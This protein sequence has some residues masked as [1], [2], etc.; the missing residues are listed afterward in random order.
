MPPTS[1]LLD[2][3]HA[4]GLSDVTAV[5]PVEG[6]LAA[7]AGLATRRSGPP[8]F[9]K[10]FVDVPAGD[11]FAAEAEGLEVLRERGELATPRVVLATRDVLVLSVLRARPAREDFW[12]R[13]AHALARLH[14]TTVH[15]RFGWERD[16]WLGRCRQE[17]AWTA[18]GHEFFARRRLL[19]WLPQR[20]VRAALDER[21]RRA[22][23]R[24]CERLPEVLPPRPPCLTHGDLWA[25]NIL[26]TEEGLPALI[27]PA[28]SYT[29]AEVDLAHLWCSPHP[30]EAKRFF[31]AYAE[32]TG[33]DDDWRSR[34]PL[35][36]LRQHLAVIA[37]FDHDWGAAQQVRD[38]LKPFRR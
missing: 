22:L 38:T 26:A 16:N 28:V 8:L 30:P 4:A 10:S 9:V 2:R 14:T 31:G 37:Q 35:I 11:L 18:D 7:L 29:W 27:D 24:L 20:R 33:L 12:E 19:R 34:M 32:L 17:N 13:F 3:V 1:L 5:E 15:D 23:E 6:G 36:Q 25:N 21:D